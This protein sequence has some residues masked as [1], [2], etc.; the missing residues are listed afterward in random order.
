VGEELKAA[1]T[2][3]GIGEVRGR[4]LLVGVEL[5]S[6]ELAEGVVN[7]VRDADV[8]INRTGPQGNVLKIRPPLVFKSEHA[9]LLIEAIGAALSG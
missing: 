6:A 4:G 9:E 7:R 8:L 2:Y 1:L 3:L 5:E